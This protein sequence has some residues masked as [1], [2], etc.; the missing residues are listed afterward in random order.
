MADLTLDIGTFT[1]AEIDALVEATIQ[2]DP[3]LFQDEVQNRIDEETSEVEQFVA[4]PAQFDQTV[5]G[6]KAYWEWRT[7]RAM[8]N[9]IA[10]LERDRATVPA[11]PNADRFT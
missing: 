10:S 5:A 2:N 7:R 1:Q 3:Q 11:T 6:V 4:V 8:R 9:N